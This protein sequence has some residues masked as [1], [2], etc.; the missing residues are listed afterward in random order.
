MNDLMLVINNLS[1]KMDKGFDKVDDRFEKVDERFEKIDHQFRKIDGQFLTI[2][3]KFKEQEI[4]FD[5]MMD[6]K[7]DDLAVI[8]NR[9]FESVE[10]SLR[11]WRLK[12]NL[13]YCVKTWIKN[14]IKL[15]IPLK[16][17]A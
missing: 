17:L 16:K 2:N 8:V 13:I 3:D 6:E 7:I 5:K 4:K 12:T 15:I 1:V 9:S 11:T 14:L 10:K